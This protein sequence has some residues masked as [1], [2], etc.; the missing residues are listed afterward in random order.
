MLIDITRKIHPGM[1]IYPNNPRVDFEQK[2]RAGEGKNALTLIHLGSH[3]GTHIDAPSHI[4][5]SGA[6]ALEYSL[7]HINGP[8]EVVDVSQ[9]D[10]V[11]TSGD[12]PGTI[13]DRV[14]F[15]TRNSLGDPDVFDDDFVALDDSAADEL[16]RRGTR[17][18]GLDALSIRKRGTKNRVHE[19]LIDN[20]IVVLEGVWL[21]EVTPGRYELMCLP[22]KVD[23]D[24]APVRA[25]LKTT[26]S[27]A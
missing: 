15:R 20:G 13:S 2:Q 21:K 1:A 3:T 16:V 9:L 7:D 24:G 27:S 10:K 17:L 6:G 4:H 19:T 8:A 23:L 5:D 26:P 22:L 12:I 18:V 14:L 11:I 25:V